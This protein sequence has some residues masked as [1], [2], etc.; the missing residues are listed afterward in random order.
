MALIRNID[1]D[2]AR[3]SIV[4]NCLNIFRDL[5]ITPLVEGIETKEE[6]ICLRDFGVE[7]MQGYLFAKPGFEKLPNVDFNLVNEFGK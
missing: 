2:H 4:K 6:F 5:N 3:Q 7:L 1:S